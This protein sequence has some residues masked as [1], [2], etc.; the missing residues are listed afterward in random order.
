MNNILYTDLE[1]TYTL[2]EYNRSHSE[3]LLRKRVQNEGCSNID[4]VFKSVQYIS[5]PTI[6]AGVQISTISDQTQ[7]K[8]L[9][10]TFNFNTD[11]GY[12]IYSIKN[13]SQETYYING[14]VFGV[15]RN[16][17]DILV[18]SLG[19]FTWSDSNKLIYWSGDSSAPSH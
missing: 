9:K 13:L 17:L 7:I 19:D 15:F 2:L 16:E 10:K 12:L 8:L 3:L 1:G 5:I 14:G 18:S 11:Y 6:L 4:I